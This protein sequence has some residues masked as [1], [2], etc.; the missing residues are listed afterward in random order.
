MK[1]S[2]KEGQIPPKDIGLATSLVL[3][4]LAFFGEFSEDGGAK[5]W[6][7]LGIIALIATMAVPSVWKP[8]LPIWKLL[9]RV[10]ETVVSKVLLSV[11]FF[12]VIFP[13]AFIRRVF[14][15]DALQAGQWKKGKGSVFTER[16][17]LFAPS[18]LANPY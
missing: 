8:L 2:T 11:V 12:G 3:F 14:G 15:K 4:L 13:V 1:P 16:G 10:L 18:D 7:A 17:Q 9:L 6:L 5:K